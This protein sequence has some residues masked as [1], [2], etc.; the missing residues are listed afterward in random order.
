MKLN[1]SSRLKRM[2]AVVMGK[3]ALL[4]LIAASA[5]AQTYTK[6][7]TYPEDTRNDTGIGLAGFMTQGRDGN[8]YGTI[9]DDGSRAAG[10]AFQMTT[11][12]HFTKIYSFCPNATCLDG[13]GP[14]GGLT[15]GKDGN[16]Y[17]TTTSGGTLGAGTVF[18]LTPTGTVSTLW[19]FDN[20]T[21]AGA[22]W[23]PPL[24][25]LD[26]NFY[27][28]SNTVY[29]GDY[30]AFFKLTP[31]TP[32]P[33]KEA[34]L[35]D[36]NYTN[37]DD[38]NLPTQG[39]DG[40]FYGTSVYGGSKGL[41]VVYKITG[42]GTITGLHNFT[43]Y[44]ADGTYP[45]GA[46]VQANDGAYYGVTYQGGAHNLG[47]VFKITSS[48]T[49]TLLHSFAGYPTDG[50]YPRSGLILGSDGNLYG[51][52]LR[53][54]K[55]NDGAIYTI[56]TAGA[57]TILH[58]LCAVAGCTDGFYTAT[59]L[60]Q[61]TNGKFYGNTSGN[62]LGGS[63]FYSLNTGLAPFAKIVN[64]AGKVGTTVELLGQGF[65]GTTGVSF[66][67]VTATFTNVSDTYMTATVPAGATTGTV[68]VTTFTSKMASNRAFLVV[69]QISGFSPTSGIVG[70]S[71]VITGV[72][73]KQATKVSIGGVAAAFKVNSDTQVTATVP[74]GA[75]TGG[76]ITVTT[77]GGV[78]TSSGTFTV[79][80]SIV[81]FSPTSGKVGAAVTIIGNSFTG[82]TKVTFGGV[83]AT[84]LQEIDDTK[85][86]ALVPT[87]A[88]T[89]P[90]AVT[91]PGGTATSSTSFTV[92]P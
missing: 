63:Y 69:P 64:W 28:V 38:P 37:G 61:H 33:Y 10:S 58:S 91:T 8:L 35:V 73:L 89:G 55:A 51:T 27:G 54:G 15:L 21:D 2:L 75:K 22:P 44:P 78:A 92:M 85:V 62:S 79:V 26:G 65:T 60:V 47:S 74:A 70:T 72:S 43:G 18:K 7:Y 30:G 52:T 34:V 84:S 3:T 49:Y 13:S 16:L 5:V 20:G 40:N 66:N 36:F 80:P 77:P 87:G 83:A 68:T 88:K 32:P 17:G 41:G 29:A 86:D 57:V 6:L 67:G 11:G 71:V 48:G 46:L 90:I 56:T 1:R 50:T 82:T 53:G 24:Q 31:S 25:G 81:S 42:G 59:P 23:Y 14:W 12:G 76:R 4:C 19:S 45:L 39:T 9:G